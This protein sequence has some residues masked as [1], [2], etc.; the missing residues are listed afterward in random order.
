MHLWGSVSAGMSD[1]PMRASFAVCKP[2][3]FGVRG[4]KDIRHAAAMHGTGLG[5]KASRVGSKLKTITWLSRGRSVSPPPAHGFMTAWPHP[6]F[7][8]CGIH[9]SYQNMAESKIKMKSKHLKLRH[10]RKRAFDPSFQF[11]E[12][13]FLLGRLSRGN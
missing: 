11:R 13:C 8:P 10:S 7:Y 12:G 9:L 6:C 3:G 4:Q 1:N 5:I 2:E